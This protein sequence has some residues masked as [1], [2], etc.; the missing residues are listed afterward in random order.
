MNTDITS[1]DKLWAALGYPIF[2]VALIMLFV[3]GKKDRPFIKYHAVQALAVNV[4][5]WI[6]EILLAILSSV[7]AAVTFGIGALIGCV[8]PLVWLLLIWPAILAYQGKYFEVPV[9]TKFLRDQHWIA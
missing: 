7:L 1:D 8:A 5:V 4:G 3:E 2:I 6:V 9:V